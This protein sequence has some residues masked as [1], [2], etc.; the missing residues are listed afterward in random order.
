M[1][2]IRIAQFTGKGIESAPIGVTIGFI[3]C[4]APGTVKKKHVDFKVFKAIG[5]DRS[6]AF[7][8]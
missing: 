6:V 4:K 2:G 8:V 3:L 1:A 5:V 7:I